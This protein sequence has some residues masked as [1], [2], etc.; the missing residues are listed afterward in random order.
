M[1]YEKYGE[2]VPNINMWKLGLSPAEVRKYEPIV[3]AIREST[4]FDQITIKQILESN[5]LL[6][7]K[8]ELIIMY[9]LLQNVE[10]YT[11]EF[12]MMSAQLKTTFESMVLNYKE[13]GE[14]LRQLE[15]KLKK[16][17][18]QEDGMKQKVLDI[19]LPIS[20]KSYV[21]ERYLE[22]ISLEKNT[23]TKASVKSWLDNVMKIPFG[24]YK[25]DICKNIDTPDLLIHI[26]KELDKKLY[27]MTEVKEQLLCIFN[28]RLQNSNASG[29][30]I[31]MVGEPGVGKCLHP[32]E[33]VI[34]FNGRCKFAKDIVPGDELMGDD[35]TKR[36]VLN[37][38]TGF[39]NMFKI[40]PEDGCGESFIVNSPHLLSLKKGLNTE[41]IEMSVSDYIQLSELESQ[42]YMG[43]RTG[44]LFEEIL[45]DVCPYE[46]GSFICFHNLLVID[47]HYNIRSTMLLAQYGIDKIHNDFIYNSINNRLL[48]IAA[49]IDHCGQSIFKS[50]DV[51]INNSLIL[52]QFVFL[53]RSVGFKCKLT[54]NCV[55]VTGN[56]H[57]I[58]SKKFTIE[59]RSYIENVF[60]FSVEYIGNGRYCGFELTGNKRFLLKDFTVTHN[61]SIAKAIA[62]IL[63]LP[64]G[65]ISL[66]GMV[67]SC[68]LDGQG[69]GWVGSSSGKIVKILQNNKCMNGVILFD[70]VDKLGQTQ[71][72]KDVQYSL[73]HITDFTQNTEF[74]DHYVGH[75]V[76]IDLSKMIFIYAMNTTSEIDPALL[77]RM[78]I[79]KIPDYNKKDKCKILIDYIHPQLVKNCGWTTDDII[80]LPEVSNY[81]IQK[82][83]TIKGSE[84]GVRRIKDFL[85]VIVNKVSLLL[86]IPIDKRSEIS[87]TFDTKKIT[88]PPLT[89]TTEIID[90][91]YSAVLDDNKICPSIAHIYT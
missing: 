25:E 52:S 56:I 69:E 58:P 47:A 57:I 1:Q 62:E 15:D 18:L 20:E 36:I 88:T 2:A 66:G 14:K 61:T 76:S 59:K 22:Y 48:V 12:V 55:R 8:K 51:I 50:Y 73:L 21:Y 87:L 72:G 9:D 34:M 17:I 42:Q 60:R 84:G 75:N 83:N 39:D 11:P 16:G 53:C 86:R 31:G 6:K 78:P 23:T 7:D 77:S 79:V 27:G 24:K 19:D 70:E 46:Y 4:D 29:M 3:N 90:E 41:P 85:T 74:K 63:N 35:S 65:Q 49:I 44:V 71:H 45:L 10:P 43:Y 26:K 28:N 37:T 89:L 13:D 81:I 54:N 5:L 32:L 38:V 40:I 68:L 80:L 33:M 82:V 91:L 64:F 30:A 67:D